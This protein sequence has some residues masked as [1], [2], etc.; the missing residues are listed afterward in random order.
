MTHAL[1]TRAARRTRVRVIYDDS[2]VSFR[3]GAAPTVGDVAC[4]MGHLALKR[5]AP[6][7]AIDV[8]LPAPSPVTLHGMGT[9][10][11]R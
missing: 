1:A 9:P 10:D 5:A 7:V 11:G 6:P 4:A 8:R 2:V 3:L